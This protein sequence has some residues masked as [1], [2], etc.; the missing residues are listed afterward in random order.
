MKKITTGLLAGIAALAVAGTAVAATAHDHV[1]KIALPD[2]SVEHIRYRGDVAP[3]V[4]LLPAQTMPVGP[5]GP[6]AL[7]EAPFADFD[8]IAAEM[9]RQADAMF[10]Q[11]ATMA[12]APAGRDGKLDT[13]AFGKLPAGTFH[14]SFVSM[15]TGNGTCSR[16]VE[17]TSYGPDQKPKLVSQS[18]GDCGAAEGRVTPAAVPGPAAQ[19]LTP[20]K[21]RAPQA[22]ADGGPTI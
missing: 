16:S 22:R 4:V 6:V 14:Y 2:G 3:Q 17:M 8:R 18:S 19:P 5:V 10:R 12:A 9:D 15:S 7:F 20:V 13:V 11:V 1:L 21:A